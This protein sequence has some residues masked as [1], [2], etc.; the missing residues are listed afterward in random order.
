MGHSTLHRRKFIRMGLKTAGVAAVMKLFPCVATVE[1]GKRRIIDSFH[2]D[3]SELA[4]LLQS[5]TRKGGDFADIFLEQKA[6]REVQCVNGA[7][8]GTGSHLVEGLA[9]R[10]F[11]GDKTAFRSSD[12]FFRSPARRAARALRGSFRTPGGHFKFDRYP[13]R[14]AIDAGVIIARKRLEKT[15][16]DTIANALLSLHAK[17]LS[18]SNLLTGISFSY[19]DEVRRIMVAN[20]TGIYITDTQPMVDIRITCTA[21]RGAVKRVFT[22]RLSHRCGFD[23]LLNPLLE[24]MLYETASTAVESLASRPV[25]GT[26][27]PVVLS[28]DAA[29]LFA[30]HLTRSIMK[31]TASDQP[32]SRFASCITVTDNGRLINGRGSSHFDDEGSPTTETKLIDRGEVAG[33]LNR[34]LHS[35]TDTHS[36]TGN[37][38]RYDY[39][40]PPAVCPTNAILEISGLPSDNPEDVLDDGLLVTGAAPLLDSRVPGGVRLNVLSGYRV[41]SGHR[42]QPVQNFVLSGHLPDM[43]D[44]IICAGPRLHFIAT[45]DPETGVPVSYGAPSLLFSMMDIQDP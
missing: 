45:E 15:S 26:R 35:K 30:G 14:P 41:R 4:A 13:Q 37:A 39:T 34:R 11:D 16:V 20:T 2:S 31:Q 9:I 27:M 32:L 1:A 8:A 7:I 10:V 23:I 40:R 29:A 21:Q 33:V 42:K 19:H 6:F 28:S 24:T 17:G 3:P 38:R 12:S 36:L 43:L 44:R 22:R 25:S 18:V 5:A